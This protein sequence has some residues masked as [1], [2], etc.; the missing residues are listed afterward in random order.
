MSSASGVGTAVGLPAAA[1][2][3][4]AGPAA[5]SA[6]PSEAGPSLHPAWTDQ[7]AATLPHSGSV[8]KNY[9]TLTPPQ[10]C[11]TFPDC[12]LNGSKGGLL[13]HMSHV[14]LYFSLLLLLWLLSN[15]CTYLVKAHS[16]QHFVSLSYI[17]GAFTNSVG[18]C[19]KCWNS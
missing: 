6:Q 7:P 15:T 13:L 10:L 12:C 1:P 16:P 19:C 17:L 5:A 4:P 14:L 11:I 18:T 8:S 9:S 3:G 2:P